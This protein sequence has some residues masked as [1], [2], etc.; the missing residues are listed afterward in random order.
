MVN[1]RAVSFV[2]IGIIVEDFA[3]VPFEDEL[4]PGS[5]VS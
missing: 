5:S 2:R 3:R 4:V 1:V